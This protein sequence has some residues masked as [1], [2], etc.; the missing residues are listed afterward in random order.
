[1]TKQMKES[2]IDYI[3]LDK[4]KLFCQ[5]TNPENATFIGLFS[6]QKLKELSIYQNLYQAKKRY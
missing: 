1:M 6:L 5:S 2:F 4:L 3:E